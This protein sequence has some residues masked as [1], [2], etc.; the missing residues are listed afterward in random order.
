MAEYCSSDNDVAKRLV[1]NFWT[2]K[3][4]KVMY[5]GSI[6]T[7]VDM[8]FMVLSQS[9]PG[10][11]PGINFPLIAL[12][13]NEKIIDAYYESSSDVLDKSIFDY[14]SNRIRLYLL[15]RSGGMRVMD[16]AFPDNK[17]S[18]AKTEVIDSH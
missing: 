2:G 3:Q 17:L 1:S 12:V 18:I 16:F 11:W 9:A 7:D 5:C 15:R 4:T 13:K 6:K 8:K 14:D 10:T